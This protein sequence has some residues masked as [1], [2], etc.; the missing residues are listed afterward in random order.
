MGKE[1]HEDSKAK[2]KQRDCEGRTLLMSL[3]FV[4]QMTM[5]L[6]QSTSGR[7]SWAYARKKGRN[8]VTLDDLIHVIT[9]K[10]R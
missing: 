5:G 4:L 3:V 7:T 2:A 1:T 6:L 8:N 10:G 9:L